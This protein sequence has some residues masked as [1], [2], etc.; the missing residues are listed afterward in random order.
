[1][2]ERITVM[3]KG[4]FGSALLVSVLSWLPLT[5]NWPLLANIKAAY[6]HFLDTAGMMLLS[7]HW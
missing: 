6:L 2:A 4:L 1:M 3:G 5:G 7:W